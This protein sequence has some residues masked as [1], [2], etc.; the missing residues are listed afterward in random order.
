MA[1]PRYDGD[2][3]GMND[4]K[5]TTA[6]TSTSDRSFNTD[7]SPRSYSSRPSDSPSSV[8]TRARLPDPIDYS[9]LGPLP[10]DGRALADA[11]TFRMA[12]GQGTG[13]QVSTSRSLDEGEYLTRYLYGGVAPQERRAQHAAYADRLRALSNNNVTK[14]VPSGQSDPKA[15]QTGSKSPTS[16]ASIQPIASTTADLA[17]QAEKTQTSL[18]SEQQNM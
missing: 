15:I 13:R 17:D 5:A 11:A 16:L 1:P 4:Y 3:E 2:R 8:S 6:Y 12:A 10:S 9:D 18:Q 14:A 7:H